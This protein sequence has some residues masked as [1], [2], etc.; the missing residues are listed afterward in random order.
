MAF[1]V[2]IDILA[3]T[4]CL[5]LIFWLVLYAYFWY[6]GL[7]LYAYFWYL[8]LMLYAHFDIL[9][10]CSLLK[11]I[12]WIDAVCFLSTVLM[13][14]LTTCSAWSLILR[15]FECFSSSLYHFGLC[16][17]W[18]LVATRGLAIHS[19]KWYNHLVFPPGLGLVLI[20][21]THQY[22]PSLSSTTHLI[23]YFIPTYRLYFAVIYFSTSSLKCDVY[24]VFSRLTSCIV[25]ELP[26][27]VH[28]ILGINC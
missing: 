22:H 18:L 23:V 7:M 16:I 8:G 21:I 28:N 26:W 2:L 20:N 17:S 15:T 24:G 25:L 4:L 5:L 1:R 12:S 9:A 3:C 11:L 19:T 14:K 6:L 27:F 13:C 10:W